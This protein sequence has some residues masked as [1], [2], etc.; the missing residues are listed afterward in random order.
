MQSVDFSICFM[1]EVIDALCKDANSLIGDRLL[2][3]VDEISYMKDADPFLYPVNLEEE[4]DYL[5]TVHEPMDLST[6]RK[7]LETKEIISF[8]SL[9]RHLMQIVQNAKIYNPQRHTIYKQANRL[10]VWIEDKYQAI[11][12]VQFQEI[13][14]LVEKRVHALIPEWEEVD[15]SALLVAINTLVDKVVFALGK[16]DWG[17]NDLEE[18]K[19]SSRRADGR[20]SSLLSTGVKRLKTTH[21]VQNS[22]LEL[23]LG[24]S[25]P[26]STPAA[27]AVTDTNR[28]RRK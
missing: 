8:E 24:S 5:A 20:R 6:I 16:D 23:S 17:E 25:T 14:A 11:N 26:L 4:P 7:K 28:R 2:S 12:A 27:P 9:K 3:L 1:L 18:K 19:T 22:S 15:R 13:R 21:P 10:A